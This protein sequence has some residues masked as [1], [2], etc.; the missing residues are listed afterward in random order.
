MA[1][2]DVVA[3]SVSGSLAKGVARADSDVDLMVV[4]TLEAHAERVAAHRTSESKG[5]WTDYPGG[6]VDMK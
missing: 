3:V 1:R 4:L 2:S 6:Y 5:E